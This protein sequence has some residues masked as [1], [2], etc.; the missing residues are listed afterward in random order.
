MCLCVCVCALA[1][2]R[3]VMYM[4]RDSRHSTPRGARTPSQEQAAMEYLGNCLHLLITGV[5]VQV[6]TIM[7]EYHTPFHC[8]VKERLLLDMICF[9]L[10]V[11]ITI[12]FAKTKTKKNKTHSD[13]R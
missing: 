5:V 12:G 2:P 10:V 9:S 11:Y 6:P 7:R 8:Q 4:E 13:K 1:C 3:L